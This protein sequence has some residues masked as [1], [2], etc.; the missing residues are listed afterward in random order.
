MYY[1]VS[2]LNTLCK[3]K[4]PGF[5]LAALK[6]FYDSI[7]ATF[8]DFAMDLWKRSPASLFIPISEA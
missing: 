4:S 2:N 5:T 6:I 8:N 3:I 7:Y 1:T